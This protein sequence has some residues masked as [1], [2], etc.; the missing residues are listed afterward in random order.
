MVKEVYDSMKHLGEDIEKDLYDDK[1]W[2][3]NQVDWLI[4]QVSYS[5]S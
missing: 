3:I 4:K 2:A 1:T 5:N